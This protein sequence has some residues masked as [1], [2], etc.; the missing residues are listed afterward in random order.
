[1]CMR[2][3]LRD[4]KELADA[5]EGWLGDREGEALFYLA[6]NCTGK[7]VIVE[8]GSWKG[9]S[10]IWLGK[11][12]LAGNRVTIYAIDTHTGSSEHKDLYGNVWTYEEF[13]NNIKNAGLNDV[14]RPVRK[15]SSTAAED[16]KE[17][18]ELIFI[19]GAHEYELVKLDFQSWFPKM[20]TGG[21]MAFHDTTN[22]QGPRRIVEEQIFKSNHF[23]NIKI[24]DSMTFAQM[25]SH[26]SFIDRLRNRYMFLL[27][28]MYIWGSKVR[29]PWRPIFKV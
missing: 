7:G 28:N 14:V 24:V 8:I 4:T 21:I 26:N 13:Q 18:V 19:D 20:I 6:K 1:M 16:F 27:M 9:K 17:P 23:K 22:W 29:V 15:K 25:V 5:I 11:G 10:T 3:E 2:D 12:S